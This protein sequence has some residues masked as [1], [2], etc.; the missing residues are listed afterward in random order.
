[1]FVRESAEMSPIFL[2]LKIVGSDVHVVA[3]ITVLFLLNFYQHFLMLFCS[4][5]VA[6]AIIIF[7]FNCSTF[8]RIHDPISK[9]PTV[10][11]DRGGQGI[12]PLQ[13]IQY[14]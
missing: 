5:D 9:N 12:L 8:A 3:C 14:W 2:S 4:F 10:T 7:S 13:S 1:M 6:N 11:G